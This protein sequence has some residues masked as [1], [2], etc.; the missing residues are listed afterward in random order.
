MSLLVIFNN[1]MME[2]HMQIKWRRIGCFWLHLQV[3]VK[4]VETRTQACLFSMS[5]VGLGGTWRK[6]LTWKPWRISAYYLAPGFLSYRILDHQ[7]RG[8][9]THNGLS[10]PLSVT[11]SGNSLQ[12]FLQL[13]LMKA[14]YTLMLPPLILL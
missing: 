7:P 5:C 10:P 13:E 4:E 3:T 11:N 9:T 1:A 8:G 14:F 12:V 2:Y 6:E